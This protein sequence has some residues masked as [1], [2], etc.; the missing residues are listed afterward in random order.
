MTSR[1]STVMREQAFCFGHYLQVEKARLMNPM[2][3]LG[4]PD[5]IASVVGFLVSKEGE[6]SA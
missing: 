3:R 1:L 6:S 5:D 4:Q 2:E